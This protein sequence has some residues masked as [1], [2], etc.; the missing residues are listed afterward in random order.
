MMCDDEHVTPGVPTFASNCF[1]GSS[2]CVCTDPLDDT[3]CACDT[4]TTYYISDPDNPGLC[5]LPS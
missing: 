2:N 5:I 3:T 1:R 4:A